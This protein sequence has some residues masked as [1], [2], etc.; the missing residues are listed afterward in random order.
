MTE[1]SGPRT[2]SNSSGSS[3]AI[4]ELPYTHGWLWGDEAT[5]DFQC[6]LKDVCRDISTTA[7]YVSGSYKKI[8]GNVRIEERR[9]AYSNWLDCEIQVTSLCLCADLLFSR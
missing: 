1:W 4:K 5:T 3:K 7:F 8:W 9:K 2:A 6:I